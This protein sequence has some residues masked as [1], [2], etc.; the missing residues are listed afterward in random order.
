MVGL[1]K[2]PDCG[3]LKDN[4]DASREVTSEQYLEHCRKCPELLGATRNG[5]DSHTARHR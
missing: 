4:K 5:K 2:K 3:V 1:C